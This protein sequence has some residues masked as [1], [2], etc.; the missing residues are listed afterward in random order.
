VLGAPPQASPRRPAGAVRSIT[1]CW[2][3]ARRG[4]AHAS[5]VCYRPGCARTGACLGGP[6]TRCHRGTA[7]RDSPLPRGSRRMLPCTRGSCA[8]VSSRRPDE[9]CCDRPCGWPRWAESR[10]SSP[11]PCATAAPVRRL[12][13]RASEHGVR[14][15][16]PSG[17][18]SR[19]VGGAPA[20]ASAWR[21]AL[22]P[23][24]AAC[25]P[26]CGD[27]RAAGPAGVAAQ[28]GEPGADAR[29]YPP[30]P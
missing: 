2:P 21:T 18:A 12:D 29:P 9:M 10:R 7:T 23:A 27:R 1:C 5:A 13:R 17:A 24:R 19:G 3:R 28:P 16:A 6:H 4:P 30:P 22:P 25:C 8:T 20:A 26:S 15:P 14:V 11:R